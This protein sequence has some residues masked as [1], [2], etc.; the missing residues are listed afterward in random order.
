MQ[1]QRMRGN[2]LK[3]TVW[4]AMIM[5]VGCFIMSLG[6]H[7]FLVPNKISTGGVSGLATIFY[8]LYQLPVG[9]GM[10]LLNVPLFLLCWRFLGFGSIIKSFIG[11]AL[12]SVF[13]DLEALYWAQGAL[14]IDGLLA[15]IYGGV[16]VGIGVG[17]VFR[18]GYTTGGTDL[19]TMLIYKYSRYSSGMILLVIDGIIIAL[20]GFVFNVEL[21]LYGLIGAYAT[22]KLLD[23][24]QEG[25][26]YSKAA[27]II[28]DQYEA[29]CQALPKGINRG[30]TAFPSQG[31]YT[32]K[33]RQALLC[34]VAQ[35]E[36]S[37][38][39]K[40]VYAIDPKAFVIVANTSEVLGEGFAFARQ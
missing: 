40:E 33:E 4:E 34:V 31:V 38:L 24:V 12:L 23:V 6:F 19:L 16:L 11:A 9:I 27:L 10:M 8:Y 29:L 17:L 28:S 7:I 2:S 15:A 22:S 21:A 25:I 14:V 13:I 5:T 32:G 37:Q 26:S 39:K 3:R 18:G 35:S 30:L 36:I 20:A 1:N